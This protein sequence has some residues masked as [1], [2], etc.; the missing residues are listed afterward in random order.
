MAIPQIPAAIR[1][2]NPGAM[3]LGKSAKLFGASVATVLNDGQRNKITTFP[4]SVDGA[5]AQFHLLYT[6]YAGMKIGDAIAKWGGGNDTNDYLSDIEA[7]TDF[8]RHDY[9]TKGLIEDPE[10]AI[11][12]AKAMAA[13]E[14]GKA[15][16]MA[17][18][19]WAAAHAKFLAALSAKPVVEKAKPA[20]AMGSLRAVAESELGQKEVPGKQ[21]NPVIM[22]WY[23]DA[24]HPEIAHDETPNCAA[25]MC[26]W[27]EHSGMANPKTLA[28][29]DFLK[30]GEPL[31]EPEENCIVVFWRNSPKSWEGHVALVVGW[32]ATQVEVLGANQGNTVSIRKFPR[33]QVLGFRRAVPALRPVTEI[34]KDTSVQRKI[35][36]G[37]STLGVLLYTAWSTVIGWL[38][39]VFDFF[40]HMVGLLPDTA[41]TVTATVASGKVIAETGGLPWPAQLSLLIAALAILGGL[42]GTWKRLRPVSL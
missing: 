17:D 21:G 37:G 25:A 3:G 23:E 19:E 36:A 42:Y 33:S 5:A 8:D 27:L 22:A 31:S 41:T 1:H 7:D 34:A 39:W 13:H 26:S 32:T 9:L 20:P 14:T 10:T 11:P 15:Y 24:G 6:T 12:F 40:G 38:G 16:P 30:Y 35:V 29:R 2:R 4:T 28:A 18:A